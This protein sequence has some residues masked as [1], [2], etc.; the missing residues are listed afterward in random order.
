MLDGMGLIALFVFALAAPFITSKYFARLGGGGNR[1]IVI[2]ID[3]SYSMGYTGAGKSGHERAKEHVMQFLDD[4]APGDSVAI[5]QAKQQVVPVQG[6]LVSDA[7]VLRTA[8]QNLAP[9]RGG[10]DW[11]AALQTATQLLENS[12]RAQR[13]IIVPT[14]GQR[15][16]WADDTSLLKWELLANK[17]GGEGASSP[18]LGGEPRRGAARQPG[19]LVAVAVENQPARGRGGARSHL[20]HGCNSTAARKPRCRNMPSSIDGRPAGEIKL[21]MKSTRSG[22]DHLQAPLRTTVGLAPVTLRISATL[23]PAT[24]ARTSPSRSC[25]HCP[26]SSSMATTAPARRFAGPISC[27]TP[28]PQRAI[29]IPRFLPG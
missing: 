13:E 7:D 24:T 19:Q 9:P 4:M 8:V 14:D 23:C 17:I 20:P 18:H 26:C 29:P 11:P 1:D 16:G 22:A 12:Q 15:F 28:S 27:A 10:A 25:P 21:R 6:A 2:I 3:G 5:F